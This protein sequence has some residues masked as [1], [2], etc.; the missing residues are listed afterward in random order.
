MFHSRAS[1]ELEL[2][3]HNDTQYKG[4]GEVRTTLWAWAGAWAGER[5]AKDGETEAAH[6][7]CLGRGLGG[8]RSGLGMV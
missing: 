5:W 4:W 1:R 3:D 7:A 2:L 8:W 6:C